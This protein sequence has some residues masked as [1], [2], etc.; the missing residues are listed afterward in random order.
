MLNYHKQLCHWITEQYGG[1]V[2]FD[3]F[4]ALHVS[5]LHQWSSQTVRV[6][7]MN[8]SGP[9]VCRAV[10]WT[11]GCLQLPRARIMR[12]VGKYVTHTSAQ[13]PDQLSAPILG[14]NWGYRGG[15]HCSLPTRLL[16]TVNSCWQENNKE[17]IKISHW[18]LH[19]RGKQMSIRLCLCTQWRVH[20]W[21]KNS[22][23]TAF[24]DSGL[25]AACQSLKSFNLKCAIWLLMLGK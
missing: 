13:N 10:L 9:L 16:K 23:Y 14:L 8:P 15:Q 17:T 2:S 1:T 3:C 18:F 5:P 20:G 21:Y 4:R 11:W 22:M 19:L 7:F 12:L 6:Y 24:N 25:L